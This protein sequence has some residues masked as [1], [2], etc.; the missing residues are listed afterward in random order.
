[1]SRRKFLKK[2]AALAGALLASGGLTGS[3]AGFIEPRWYE[4]TRFPLSF[5]RLPNAF[6]GLKVLQFSDTHIGHFFN[7]A[8]LEQLVTLINAE[9]ADII[10]FTGDLFDAAIT[11]DSALTSKLLAS[12]E[13]PL[14]KWAVLG[15]HDKWID[16][17]Y[18]LPIL[19]DGGF[20]TL[21]NAYQTI[22]YKSQS[23]QL[24]GVKDRLTAKPDIVTTLS[25]S[26]PQ[27]FTLLLSHCPDYANEVTGYPIDLQLSGHTHGGQIRL[28]VAGALLTPPQGRH[29]VVGLNQV[30]NSSMLVYTNRGI[31]TTT[32]PLRFLCRPEITVITLERQKP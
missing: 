8:D 25:G 14:G 9:K 32:L 15:N 24:A 20:R 2:G 30:P 12:I 23:I 7:L 3:Y 11:E 22:T 21:Q 13:A 4:V 27:M 6:H 31:G 19:E 28:P 16:I 5:A 29:Y 1:M 17:N 26:N 10:T 18:T